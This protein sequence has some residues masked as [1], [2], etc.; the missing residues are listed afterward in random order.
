MPDRQGLLIHRFEEKA[1]QPARHFILQPLL[2][3]SGLDN[4]ASMVDSFANLD[5]VGHSDPFARPI[6][7]LVL[8]CQNLV[9]LHHHVLLDDHSIGLIVLIL[10][11]AAI[12]IQ[13]PHLLVQNLLFSPA[14]LLLSLL[15]EL[16]S[17]LESICYV[18]LLE[19]FISLLSLLVIRQFTELGKLSHLVILLH[20][21][22]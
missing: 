2:V 13:F 6:P 19:V 17:R 22:V 7:N 3:V 9:A 16:L 8:L 20:E 4:L 15:L 21:R 11:V 5:D 1:L 14:Y 10:V 18:L 12:L